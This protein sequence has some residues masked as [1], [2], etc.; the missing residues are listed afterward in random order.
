MSLFGD[1]P[2]TLDRVVRLSLTVGVAWG[3]VLLLGYLSDV[4]LPFA[5]AVLLAYI[6][7]PLVSWVQQRVRSRALA[8]WLTL[9]ATG[10]CVVGLLW[11]LIPLIGREMSHM[12]SLVSDLVNNSGLAE[13]AA[14]R[15][16]PDI[17]MWIKEQLARP[18]IRSMFQT[19]NVLSLFESLGQRLVPGIWNIIA[20]TASF[21]FWVLGLVFIFMYLVFLLLDFQRFK[22]SSKDLIPSSW[23]KPVTEFLQEFDQGM[24]RYFRAQAGVAS[25]VGVLF[26]IGFAMIGLPLSILLGLFIGLLNMVPYL[27]T[28]GL[29]PALL[30]A[31]V[32]ALETGTS[33]WVVFGLTGLVFLVIQAIQDMVL[34][35]KIMGKVMGLSPAMILLSLSIW[36]KLLGFLGLII[37]LP[38][39]CLLLAYYKRI[40]QKQSREGA[41]AVQEN[42]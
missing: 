41:E 9:A 34:V 33:F 10:V 4:I 6:L 5:V 8:V 25:I 22:D 18:E 31:G 32:H 42:G 24:S 27:Q 2:Y 39:T 1:R 12:G 11:V 17:W 35:P 19:D 7:H 30:L 38:V 14:K 37:A 28:I 26:A 40:I 16:P 29:I 15:L 13:Q 20:G 3:A 36:G 23:R 21:L